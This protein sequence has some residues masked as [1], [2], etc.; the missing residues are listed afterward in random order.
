[1]NQTTRSCS[2]K[3]GDLDPC[4]ETHVFCE[5]C[6]E[7]L[8]NGIPYVEESTEDHH[9]DHHDGSSNLSLTKSLLIFAPIMFFLSTTHT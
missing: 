1:M 3:G 6:E 8:C 2:E 9:I 7:D 5:S 4:K